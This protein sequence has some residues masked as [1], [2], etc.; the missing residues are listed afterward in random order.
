M[1]EVR[2]SFLLIWGKAGFYI[3]MRAAASH[4]VFNWLKSWLKLIGAAE[5]RKANC[6]TWG[7]QD[8]SVMVKLYNPSRHWVAISGDLQ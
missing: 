3:C 7:Q 6:F 2:T 1:V 8:G 4:F 5:M